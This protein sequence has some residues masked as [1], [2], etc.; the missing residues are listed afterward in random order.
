MPI[1]LSTYSQLIYC[2]NKSLILLQSLTHTS[3]IINSYYYQVGHILLQSAL[4][5]L[6]YNTI[7]KWQFNN[8]KQYTNIHSIQNN[9]LIIHTYLII[10]G[11]TVQVHLKQSPSLS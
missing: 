4:T 5:E 8:E 2:Y 11:Q 6:T 3:S 9:L 10:M 1:K 7:I